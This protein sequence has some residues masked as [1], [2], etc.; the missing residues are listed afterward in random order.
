[1]H[2]VPGFH[3]LFPIPTEGGAGNHTC[4]FTSGAGSAEG[5]KRS[6]VCATGM[7]AVA[8]RLLADEKFAKCVQNDFGQA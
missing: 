1:M 6:I 3:A 7:T 2:S 8:C 4:G 5:Y